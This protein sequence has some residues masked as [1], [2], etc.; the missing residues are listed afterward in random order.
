MRMKQHRFLGEL[1]AQQ[2][3]PRGALDQ[4]ELASKASDGDYFEA[5]YVEARVREMKRE[6]KL[7]SKEKR[8]LFE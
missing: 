1:Y 7:S 4:F 8:A 5:S 3:N 2:A 6:I